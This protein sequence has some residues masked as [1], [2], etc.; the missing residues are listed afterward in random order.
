M[1]T[2]SAS[3][4]MESYVEEKDLETTQKQN[5]ALDSSTTPKVQKEITQKED[6]K[7]DKSQNADSESADLKAVKKQFIKTGQVR[8]TV[9]NNVNATEQVEFVLRKFGGYISNS[10]LNN[11]I[12]YERQVEMSKDSILEVYTEQGQAKITAAVPHQHLDS[13]LQQILRVYSKVNYRK[14]TAEDVSISLLE[15]RLKALANQQSQKRLQEKTAESK[16]KL[17]SIVDAEDAIVQRQ[18]DMIGQQ[19]ANLRLQD[20]IIYATVDIELNQE[21][22]FKSVMRKNTQ[23]SVSSPLGYRLSQAFGQGADI[24]KEIVL[25]LLSGWS[26]ILGIVGL[27]MLYRYI[28]KP[29]FAKK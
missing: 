4:A 14:T 13:A 22:E 15:N 26:I 20:R 7:E 19:I 16:D 18:M 9:K 17:P 27:V 6:N 10:E 2:T 21:Q 25:F 3:P 8:G 12:Y 24:L 29:F 5:I 1:E 28:L 11:Q 23:K